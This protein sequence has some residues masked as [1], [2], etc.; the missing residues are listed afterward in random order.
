MGN[1]GSITFTYNNQKAKINCQ[2]LSFDQVI[3]II[4]TTFIIDQNQCLT[5]KIHHTNNYISTKYKWDTLAKSRKPAIQILNQICALV[6]DNPTTKTIQKSLFKILNKQEKIVAL[7]IKISEKLALCPRCLLINKEI[8]YF[9]QNHEIEFFNNKRGKFIFQGT[10]LLL[11]ISKALEHFFIVQIEGPCEVL[12][13]NVYNKTKLYRGYCL[14]FDKNKQMLMVDEIRNQNIDL[15]R[16]FSI[17]KNSDN[18]CPGALI[19]GKNGEIV[20]VYGGNLSKWHSMF[21]V[22]TQLSEMFEFNSEWEIRSDL[23]CIP[24]ICVYLNS[25][26]ILFRD[27]LEIKQKNYRPFNIFSYSK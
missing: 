25:L 17:R 11:G 3:E 13:A 1:T 10:F 20:A 22:Y 21:R 12:N 27:I 4:R 26:T 18:W 14:Y 15:E 9:I 19:I 24:D 8:D 6:I 23:L 5:L 7:G 16:Y 2:N